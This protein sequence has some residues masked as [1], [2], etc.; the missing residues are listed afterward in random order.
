MSRAAS[1]YKWIKHLYAEVDEIKK[2]L[3]D[4]SIIIYAIGNNNNEALLI[5][6]RE[7]EETLK[8]WAKRCIKIINVGDENEKL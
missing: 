8:D 5:P 1:N 2:V 4:L 6:Q 7:P 3:D